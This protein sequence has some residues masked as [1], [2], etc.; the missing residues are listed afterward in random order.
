MKQLW[1]FAVRPGGDP[2]DRFA[3]FARGSAWVRR[4]GIALTIAIFWSEFAA[5]SPVESVRFPVVAIAAAV[6]FE[7]A[8]WY[9]LQLERDRAFAGDEREGFRRASALFA[10]G[11]LTGALIV[12]ALVFRDAWYGLGAVVIAYAGFLFS[13]YMPDALF[14]DRG[15]VEQS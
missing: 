13:R 2:V 11:V 5:T 4:A 3:F 14:G 7:V 9:R 8:V 1:D 6:A 12:G 10:V 15:S